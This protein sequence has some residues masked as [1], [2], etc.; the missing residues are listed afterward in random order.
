MN[1][2]LRSRAHKPNPGIDLEDGFFVRT[3]NR[4]VLEKYELLGHGS[5]H[6]L[7]NLSALVDEKE[8]CLPTEDFTALKFILKRFMIDYEG[9][10]LYRYLLLTHG[11]ESLN[12]SAWCHFAHDTI[13]TVCAQTFEDMHTE[14]LEQF[15]AHSWSEFVTSI[16][17][18]GMK[19]IMQAISRRKDIYV[20]NGGMPAEMVRGI[21]FDSNVPDSF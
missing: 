15:G 11:P 18:V 19:D 21:L 6:F 9:F 16:G 20:E 12:Y 2:C 10:R 14:I 3:D 17:K 5:L 8:D 7:N 4:S 1:G 13:W